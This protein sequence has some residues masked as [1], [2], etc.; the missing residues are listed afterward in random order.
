ML[1][2][3]SRDNR[4]VRKMFANFGFNVHLV[5]FVYFRN[6]GKYPVAYVIQ[7][8]CSPFPTKIFRENRRQRKRE[9]HQLWSNELDKVKGKGRDK[10]R[11]ENSRYDRNRIST[12]SLRAPIRT[13]CH[14]EYTWKYTESSFASFYVARSEKDKMRKTS[15][16][17]DWVFFVA[18]SILQSIQFCVKKYLYVY[19][20]S[21]ALEFFDTETLS[22]LICGAT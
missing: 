15:L 9:M 7:R 21:R 11:T 6:A 16:T 12:F 3:L 18:S 5:F 22:N 1:D 4:I 14:S 19:V 8:E 2:F 17:A 20:T 13:R 10:S